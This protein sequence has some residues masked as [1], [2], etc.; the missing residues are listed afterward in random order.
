MSKILSS[1]KLSAI[2]DPLSKLLQ[3]SPDYYSQHA[4]RLS[5]AVNTQ[6]SVYAEGS[7]CTG[8]SL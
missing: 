4:S 5:H 7:Q 8:M 6:Q 3:Y 1:L 2:N